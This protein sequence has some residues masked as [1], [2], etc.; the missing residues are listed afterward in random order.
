MAE[1]NRPLP[2][3]TTDSRPYWDAA[4]RH[5]FMMQKCNDCG[6][7]YMPPAICCHYCASLN[8]D[9][10][11]VSGKGKVFTYTVVRRAFGPWADAV[12]YV[13][14]IVETEEGSRLTT[15][16]VGCAPEDVRVDMPVEV[17]FDDVTE[18]VS[19]PK[20]KPVGA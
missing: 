7:V 5:E 18:D 4:K 1:Y 9:W 12:P 19:L 3:V 10:V 17:V 15:N 20:F 14:A 6:H 8:V 16:I 11:K 13:I 2:P